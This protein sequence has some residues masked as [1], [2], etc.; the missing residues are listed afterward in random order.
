MNWADIAILTVI[1]ISAVISLFRGFVREVLSLLAWVVAIWVA[2]VFTEQ[3]ATI[4]ID[5]ISVPTVRLVIAFVALLMVT[6]ILAGI[7]NHLIGKLIEK[8]G[9]S[10]TDRMLGIVFGVIRGGAIVA[11]LVMLAGLTP[12][13]RDPWWKE[14]MLLP[15]FVRAAHV[16]LVRLPPGVGK[17][18]SY[19]P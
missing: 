18:F 19:Q 5:H 11:L 1:G 4:L 8:T 3:V 12:V 15:H 7:V 10:G 13:P 6:L 17:H 9:L 14:S 16:V 2:F